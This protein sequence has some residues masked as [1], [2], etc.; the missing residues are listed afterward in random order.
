MLGFL[1][2][3]GK[4]RAALFLQDAREFG[5]E[6]TIGLALGEADAEDFFRAITIH[7]SAEPICIALVEENFFC[8]AAQRHEQADTRNKRKP[9]ALAAIKHAKDFL[10]AGL[11]LALEQG[12]CFWIKLPAGIIHC[13]QGYRGILKL[14]IGSAFDRFTRPVDAVDIAIAYELIVRSWG[15]WKR[16]V[17]DA[18]NGRA[19]IVFAETIFAN[20]MACW[21]TIELVTI[22]GWPPGIAGIFLAPGPAGLRYRNAVNDARDRIIIRTIFR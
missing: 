21:V 4:L 20:Q 16:A 18:L 2:G 22:I 1:P 15:I 7:I 3:F 6:T 8:L 11:P 13:M 9:L 17:I 5:L 19:G 14:V 10:P 12:Q